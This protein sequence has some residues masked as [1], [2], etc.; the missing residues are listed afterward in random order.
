MSAGL[1]QKAIFETLSID[2]Q[3][4]SLLGGPRVYDVFPRDREFPCVLIGPVN[5]DDWSNDTNAG[6]AVIATLVVWCDA[7]GLKQTYALADRVKS[8]CETLS[9]DPADGYHI[10]VSQFLTARHERDVAA[11]LSKAILRFRIL[12]EP[13]N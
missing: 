8:I 2:A 1:V 7:K 12:V 5:I 11:R 3:L 4:V 9:I 10:V 6:A 13:T